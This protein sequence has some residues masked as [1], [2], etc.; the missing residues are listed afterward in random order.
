MQGV[1][2]GGGEGSFFPQWCC[3]DKNVHKFQLEIKSQNWCKLHWCTC[4]YVSE[5]EL[6]E[7]TENFSVLCIYQI[8]IRA[9][10]APL[11]PPDSIFDKY[12]FH[13]AAT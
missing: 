11:P 5:V 8:R 10:L 7:S 4:V 13:C 6:S 9:Q 3:S 2:T 1:N 12:N